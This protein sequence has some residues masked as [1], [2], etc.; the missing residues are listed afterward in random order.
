MLPTLVTT[1]EA[2]TSAGVS[3]ARVR[4]WAS[5]GILTRYGRVDGVAYYDLAD[6]YRVGAVMRTGADWAGIRR[7]VL[8]DLPVTG[9]THP[10][11][12]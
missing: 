5:R 9:C 10:A 7:A 4:K 3:E 1:R 11:P 12:V 6:V 2:A 8:D